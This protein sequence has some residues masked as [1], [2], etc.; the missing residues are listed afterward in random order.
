MLL[1][2]QTHLVSA[3][4]CFEGRHQHPKG[5]CPLT[6]GFD[7]DLLRTKI[8]ASTERKG[9][10]FPDCNVGFVPF[11]T[12]RFLQVVVSNECLQI[13]GD[14]CRGVRLPSNNL[15]LQSVQPPRQE[16]RGSV[17]VATMIA[18][19]GLPIELERV[20]GL[21]L[22]GGMGAASNGTP[23]DARSVRDRPS[24]VAAAAAAAAEA[25]G[26][27]SDN[28]A[29]TKMGG[30]ADGAGLEKITFEIGRGRVFK[31]MQLPQST[32]LYIFFGQQ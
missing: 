14:C 21:E 23:S 5:Y 29:A 8:N 16:K 11:R 24:G 1:L 31:S 19:K 6:F 30:A 7:A 4:P 3:V 27:G 26:G 2:F 13:A 28:T 9:I 15:L 22:L 25:Y 20:E 10:Y 17:R 18:M 32:N 12:F